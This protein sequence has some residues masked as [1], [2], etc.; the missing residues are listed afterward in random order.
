MSFANFVKRNTVLRSLLSGPR[1]LRRRYLRWRAQP[2]N[3]TLSIL[4]D[5]L[6]SDVIIRVKEFDGRFSLDARSDLFRRIA[7][8]GSYEPRLVDIFRRCVDP[9]R[10][11]VDIGANAGFY[12]VLGAKLTKKRVLSVE[13]TT[14]MAKRLLINLALNNVSDQV[15]VFEGLVSDKTGVSSINFIPG[16]EEYSSIGKL[17]HPSI[18]GISYESRSVPSSTLDDLIRQHDLNPGIIKVDV[19]GAEGLVFAGGLQTLKT[20]RPFVL[21]EFS[22]VLLSN[23]GTSPQELISRFEQLN[24]VVLDPIDPK[25]KLGCR[26]FSDI[27]AVPAEKNDSRIWET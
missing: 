2:L 23:M 24:Y 25:A 26:G 19:E 10:D 3:E 18:Y 17:V 21:S 1:A 22:T 16:K 12:S 20:Y 15:V 6:E 4:S 27:L 14:T 7:I 5:I 13:P 9:G 8:S 11:V